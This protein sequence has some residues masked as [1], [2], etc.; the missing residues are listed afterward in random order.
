MVLTVGVVPD[1]TNWAEGSYEAV[2]SVVRG[3]AADTP[4]KAQATF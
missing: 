2:V 3:C 1:V 4:N